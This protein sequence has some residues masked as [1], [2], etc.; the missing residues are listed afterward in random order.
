MSSP[1]ST[2]ITSTPLYM[3]KAGVS[4]QAR[5]YEW[6]KA[7]FPGD[8][9]GAK[10]V[11]KQLLEVNHNGQLLFM[12]TLAEWVARIVQPNCSPDQRP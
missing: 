6:E 8:F 12:T 11:E 3:N 5:E 7:Y 1:D 9:Y 10:K 4:G 2:W